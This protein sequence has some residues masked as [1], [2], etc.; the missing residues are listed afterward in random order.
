MAQTL[1]L[2]LLLYYA[3]GQLRVWTPA[4]CE[5]GRSLHDAD[6]NKLVFDV[7]CKYSNIVSRK[8]FNTAC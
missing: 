7:Q 6:T 3:H 4:S 5:D 2:D 1:S 8:I